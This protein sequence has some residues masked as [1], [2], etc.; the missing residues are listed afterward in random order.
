MLR[1]QRSLCNSRQRVGSTTSPTE[2]AASYSL[3]AT[4][5]GGAQT[6]SAAIS[7]R[8]RRRFALFAGDGYTNREI[9]ERLFISPRTLN[10]TSARSSRSSA[11]A[12]AE[13]LGDTAGGPD[14]RVQR[15]RKGWALC[16][17][18]GAVRLRA[19][20]RVP[21]ASLGR[22]SSDMHMPSLG[23]ATEWLNVEPRVIQPL[24]DVDRE[25]VDVSRQTQNLGSGKTHSTD[26][27]CYL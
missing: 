12:L 17:L 5:S 2:P 23:G 18:G 19:A 11:L 16:R 26:V 25:P 13:S 10:G 14:R 1:A 24:I 4:R 8:R 20:R 9:G 27:A 21:L 6:T 15:A 3:P 22:P 7:P